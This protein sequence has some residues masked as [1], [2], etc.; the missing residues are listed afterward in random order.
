MYPSHAERRKK[1]PGRV[2][3]FSKKLSGTILE[4][5]PPSLTFKFSR[6]FWIENPIIPIRHRDNIPKNI[7]KNVQNNNLNDTSRWYVR[8]SIKQK[9]KNRVELNFESRGI[10]RFFT[11]A[12]SVSTKRFYC[13]RG[14]SSN[15]IIIYF[16]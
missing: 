10:E 16:V 9:K 4:V 12:L 6:T 7:S 8:F 11:C 3:G 5:C 14:D 2:K 15:T 1:F 13:V